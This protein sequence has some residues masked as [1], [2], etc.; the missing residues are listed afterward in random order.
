[1]AA[2]T[3]EFDEV[4]ARGLVGVGGKAGGLAKLVCAGLP[5]PDGF[6][7]PFDVARCWQDGG[8]GSEGVW[9]D[10]QARARALGCRYFAVRS[11][12]NIEDGRHG[13]VPGVFLSRLAVT[14]NGLREAVTDVL[15]S[16]MS[17]IAVHCAAGREIR[18]AV[19]VQRYVRPDVSGTIYTRPIGEPQGHTTILQVNCA[20]RV[21]TICEPR[22]VDELAAELVATG[23]VPGV[24]RRRIVELA[25]AAENAISAPTGADVE[26]IVSGGRVWIVQARPIVHRVARAAP[27]LDSNALSFSRDDPGIVWEWDAAHNPEP[28]SQAQAGLVEFIVERG[29]SPSPLRVVAGHLY[30]GSNPDR[31]LSL[32]QYDSTLLRD[33]YERCIAPRFETVFAEL[34]A[35]EFLALEDSLEA[36]AQVYSIY[37]R[38]LSPRLRY[39][40]R[41]L[42]QLLRAHVGADQAERLMYELLNEVAGSPLLAIL[43]RADAGEVT[44]AD[45]MELAGPLSP[46]WDVAC[47]TFAEQPVAIERAL[48]LC[49]D[50]STRVRAEPLGALRAQL[51]RSAQCH[52]DETV[53]SWCVSREIAE[54]D[55]LYFARAQALVRRSL[56]QLAHQWRRVDDEIFDV[57]LRQVRAM[58]AEGREPADDWWCTTVR[59]SRKRSAID[60]RRVMPPRIQA[61][62]AVPILRQAGSPQADLWHGRGMGGTAKG[63]IVRLEDVVTTDTLATPQWDGP[64]V[65]LARTVT[66]AM[67]P[68]LIGAAGL[69]T[70]FGGLLDHASALCRELGIPHVLNCAGALRDL[71]PGDFVV[72]DANVGSVARIC[73][74]DHQPPYSV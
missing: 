37:T 69:V 38:E 48:R 11:S 45:V 57:P 20:S 44:L 43:R 29:I 50:D 74:A 9:E 36:Y 65:V 66:P 70:E 31:S 34:E 47:P 35:D 49:G 67:L 62:I 18:M 30:V 68:M 40:Q 8:A 63:R 46:M 54:L 73:R 1:M 17:P 41:Q 58:A 22:V 59:E 33:D 61:G 4:R 60:R 6:V 26:W 28:L 21:E 23:A 14:V 24:L 56:L 27:S 64:T 72:L 52:L 13:A 53:E 55:D 39:V 2:G 15:A 51:N 7:V 3:I 71:A 42:F 12:A 10:V 19:V 32:E 16:A 5:V 25:L